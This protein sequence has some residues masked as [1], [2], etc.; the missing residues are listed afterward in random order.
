MDYNDKRKQVQNKTFHSSLHYAIIGLKTAIM[1]E[2]NMKRHLIVSVMVIL[3]GLI[4]RLSLHDWLWLFLSIFL[5]IVSEIFNTS[6][7]NLVDLVTHY[8][9]HPI[10]K[11]V[12]D[13][14]AGAVLLMSFLAVIIGLFIFIPAFLKLF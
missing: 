7:E 5:V 6:M 9:Y 10:A 2:K 3:L 14:M 1:E 12:K 13:M 4:C 8:E 11:K